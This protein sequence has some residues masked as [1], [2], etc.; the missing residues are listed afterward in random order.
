MIHAKQLLIDLDDTLWDTYHNNKHALS[1]LYEKHGWSAF[2]SSFEA[3]FAL[4]MPHCN[5]LWHLYRT[6]VINKQSLTIARL[7]YPLHLAG[8]SVTAEQMLA[9][10]DEFMALVKCETAC[11][12]GA[13]DM[14]ALLKPH[15]KI[16]I[17]TN[18][19]TE[20][21]SAKLNKSGIAPYVNQV[22]ISE[23]IGCHKP[24][25]QFFHAVL[26]ATNS[27]KSESVVIGDS[28]HADIAGAA[29]YGLRAI[30]FNLQHEPLPESFDPAPLIVTSLDQIPPLLLPPSPVPIP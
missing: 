13:L 5:H 11:V 29:A 3:Y 27:R 14:L 28:W 12:E 15:F 10:N 26:T 21:Q 9:L 24:D 17:I 19:W 2:F 20:V 6:G 1:I 23:Q 22:F 4:Y 8:Q 30:W 7:A 16:Y 18:G 25:P